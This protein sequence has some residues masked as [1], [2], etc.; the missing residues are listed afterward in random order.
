[1]VV[2]LLEDIGTRGAFLGAGQTGLVLP[3]TT[4]WACSEQAQLVRVGLHYASPCRTTRHVWPAPSVF[5]D[6]MDHAVFRNRI[7]MQVGFL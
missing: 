5:R 7:L 4:A 1:M 3:S 6:Q 2:H